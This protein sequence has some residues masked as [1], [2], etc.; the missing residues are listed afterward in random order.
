MVDSFDPL[1]KLV[2]RFKLAPIWPCQIRYE[3][4]ICNGP[5]SLHNPESD[6]RVSSDGYRDPHEI[7]GFFRGIQ[8]KAQSYLMKPIADHLWILVLFFDGNFHRNVCGTL[9]LDESNTRGQK[10]NSNGTV[11]HL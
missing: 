11:C 2:L 8:G 10:V 4:C 3:C 5:N 9:P 1:L 6:G 7:C